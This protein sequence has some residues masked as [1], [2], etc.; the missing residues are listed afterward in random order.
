MDANALVVNIIVQIMKMW[1]MVFAGSGVCFCM[2]TMWGLVAIII[3]TG[4]IH[5]IEAIHHHLL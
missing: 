5:A 3:N 4:W 1:C 2:Q